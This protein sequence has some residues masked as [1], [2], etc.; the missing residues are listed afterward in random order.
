M[1]IR[2]GI[3]F[4]IH[5]LVEKRPLYLGGVVIPYHKGLLGHSDGDCLIHAIIDALLGA[6]GEKDIGQRF[7][8]AD[9]RF[10]NIRS[11]LLLGRVAEMMFEEGKA[12]IG[13][14]DSVVIAEKPR[15]APHIPKM[16]DVLCN[17]LGLAAEDLG[18]KASSH[19]GIGPLGREEAIAA[20]ANVLIFL[21]EN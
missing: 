11:T 8:D 13:N 9:I 20:W 4:D 12:R 6:M 10:K 19:E 5:R 18:I 1:K 21:E 17:I 2:T 7:P 3:G 16:K 14:I 15:L